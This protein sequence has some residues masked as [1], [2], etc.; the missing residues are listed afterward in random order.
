MTH[1]CGEVEDLEVGFVPQVV[2]LGPVHRDRSPRLHEREPRLAGAGAGAVGARLGREED[3]LFRLV[4]VG[5]VAVLVDAAREV[6]RPGAVP[7][8]ARNEAELEVAAVQAGVAELDDFT[9]ARAAIRSF[10]SAATRAESQNVS[11]LVFSFSRKSGRAPPP[12]RSGDTHN[13][14]RP[15]G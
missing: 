14:T 1:G 12:L 13:Q 4:K 10:A 2:N 7:V 9:R 3:N 8:P 11:G 6:P 15:A 5:D